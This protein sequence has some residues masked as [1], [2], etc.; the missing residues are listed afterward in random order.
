M[1]PLREDLLQSIEI[2]GKLTPPSRLCQLLIG[3]SSKY[4]L[5][6][7]SDEKLLEDLKHYINLFSNPPLKDNFENW[8]FEIRD[9]LLQELAKYS[10]EKP[11]WPIGYTLV[12][13]AGWAN[14]P[15]PW[16]TYDIED[17][18]LLKGAQNPQDSVVRPDPNKWPDYSVDE[19]LD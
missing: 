8:N 4:R 15:R 17:E 10:E 5:I 2:A 11:D 16:L 6:K 19:F 3:A 12:N 9:Q 7:T 1:T 14:I 13:F 18:D